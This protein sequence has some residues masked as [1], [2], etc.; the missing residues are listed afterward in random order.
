MVLKIM[1][2]W[3]D[4]ID[5]YLEQSQDISE[6][7]TNGT[8]SLFIK[9]KGKRVELPGFFENEMDYFEKTKELAKMVDPDY[10]GEENYDYPKFLV[11]GRLLL[12]GTSARVHIV[13]PP[14]ADSPQVTIAKKT[15]RLST[16]KGIKDTKSMN[17]QMYDF[18]KAA[19]ACNQTIIVSGGTGSGKTTILEAMT[20]EFNYTD[21]IGV[22]EDSPELKLQQPNV[23]YLHSTLWKPGSDKNSVATLSWCVQQINRQRTDKLIIGETRGKEFADFII[24]ANSGMEGSL[25]TIHANNPRL[26]LQKMNQF[27]SQAQVQATARTVN[28]TIAAAIDIIIQLGF[29]KN[30]KNKIISITEVSDIINGAESAQIATS[31]LFTFDDEVNDW[32]F[33]GFP[34]EKLRVVLEKNNYDTKTFALKDSL[35]SSSIQPNR[36][37]K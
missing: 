24:G 16:L 20:R 31:P 3:K 34:S 37:R 28:E 9:D 36:F 29:D 13:L 5:K 10:K 15:T 22:V 32:K 26:A 19:I 8:T 4:I 35:K 14:A 25:T 6:I 18:I 1:R 2:T 21:R 12:S 23:T 17:S 11:E 7:E 33:E 30:G 27:I